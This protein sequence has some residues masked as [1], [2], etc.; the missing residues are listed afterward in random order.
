MKE[1]RETWGRAKLPVESPAVEI[2][3]VALRL[4]AAKVLRVA[5]RV[6]IDEIM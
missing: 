5:S 1:P 6:E 3:L 4:L 2:L